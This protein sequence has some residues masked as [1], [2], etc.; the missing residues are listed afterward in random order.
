LYPATVEVLAFQE[1]ATL[2]CGAGI[3]EPFTDSTVGALVAS[4]AKERFVK[5]AP[6]ACGVNFTVNEAVV[7][8]ASVKGKESPLTENSEP[9]RP[10]MDDT[11]TDAMLAESVAVWDWLVPT[12]T[13]PKLIVDG[14]TANDPAV[15]P[16]P[17]S[18]MERV[19]LEAF[20]VT[21]SVP[22]AVPLAAG[23]KMTLKV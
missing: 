10:P 5:V 14:F 12:T 18:G 15:V 11:V 19:G 21:E 4:L 9:V 13:L 3:P 20:E 23:V 7:P 1:R 17:L 22:L 8:E 16:V 2:C 6:E